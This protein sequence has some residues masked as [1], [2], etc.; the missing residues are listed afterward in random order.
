M[1]D[2]RARL[3]KHNSALTV[4]NG[5]DAGGVDRISI[6]GSSF[7]LINADGAKVDIETKHLD[8][9][10]L[11]GN[12]NVSRQYFAGAYDPAN[13]KGPDCYS[14]N[15]VGPSTGC[16]KPQ[17]HVC[18]DCPKN[19]WGTGKKN[20]GTP[21]AGKACAERKLLAVSVGAAK[22]KAYQLNVPTTSL[23]NLYTYI[24]EVCKV[25]HAGYPVEPYNVF[26]RITF[27]RDKPGQVLLFEAKSMVPDASLGFI[28]DLLD[29]GQVVDLL[30]L[31]D[32]PR[33]ALPAPQRHM[34]IEGPA[35]SVPTSSASAAERIAAARQAQASQPPREHPKP[36]AVSAHVEERFAEPEPMS[37]DLDD[38]LTGAGFGF[39]S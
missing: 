11:A 10:I 35:R 32:K 13:D 34:E 14:H 28:A 3:A 27:D 33:A 15:G 25:T 26:T 6:K 23:R 39:P 16:S 20:D 22:G 31:N 8:V 36:T 7:T 12:P 19:A 5:I 37:G 21:S 18:Q 38:L 17:H 4:L 9:I 30:S 1:T 29:S 2:I 24:K